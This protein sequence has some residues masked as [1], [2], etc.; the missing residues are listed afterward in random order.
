MVYTQGFF[1]D[2]VLKTEFPEIIRV[3]VANALESLKAVQFGRADAALVELAVANHL[4]RE[5]MLTGLAVKGDFKSS[6][7]DIEKLNIA[8]RNDWPKLQS[9]LKKA[10]QSITEDE[11]KE[12]QKKWIGYERKKAV[13]LSQEETAY[14]KTKGK[15]SYCVDPNRAPLEFID[16]E[17]ST[18]TEHQGI[19]ADMLKLLGDRLNIQFQ[20]VTTRDW[21]ESQAKVKDHV[22]D[23]LPAAIVNEE[24]KQY[25]NFTEPWLKDPLVVATTNKVTYAEKFEELIAQDRSFGVVSSYAIFKKL[26]KA[27]PDARFVAVKHIEEGLRKVVEGELFGFIDTLS[28][29]GYAI[30]VLHLFELRIAVKMDISRDAS[31]A[32][33][34]DELELA[35]ILQKGL[36]SITDDEMLTIRN[37]WIAVKFD[38]GINWKQIL[39]W[40]I[41]IFAGIVLIIATILV[42]NRK[43]GKEISERKRTEAELVKTTQAVKESEERFQTIAATTPGA[44]IQTRFDPEGRPEYLYLSAKAE[45]FF[46]MPPD[47]VIQR[48]KRLQWYHEDQKRIHEEIRTISSAGE[49][50]NL[51][52]RIEPAEGEIKWIRINASPSRSS[53]GGVIYNGFILDI[54]GRKLAEQE[55]LVSERKVKAMSQAVDDALVMING[56]GEVM[57]WNQAAEDLFGYT[58]KEAMG[59]DF[60]K[61]AVPEEERVKTMAGL[62]CFS[63]TGEG[64]VIGS[65]LKVT[66]KNRNGEEFPVE[67]SISAFQVDDEWFAVG[68]VRDI[69]ERKRAE[70]ELKQKMEEMERLNNLT[71]GREGKMIQLK[72]EINE[73]RGRLGMKN[74]YKIVS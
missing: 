70:E 16:K 57:F 49:D 51:V 42:W 56:K 19:T 14:L 38:A 73:L 5:N 65:G 8:V 13:E 69:T 45:Q 30:R 60:H 66:A 6:D 36:K 58:A 27:Y 59:M 17:K 50:M 48:K 18:K 40:V 26:Q 31:I 15:I 10:M 72:E 35:A 21:Q 7:P 52:G 47:Q 54:T 33:R 1:Y 74:R 43:L 25:L 29:V 24:R 55:Y 46:G 44:I 37:R 32:V 9:I 20:L 28:S 63:R 23:I 64:A 12:L 34:N 4:I 41:P 3:Q 11:A 53:E 61:M 22:C 67:V 2:E 39:V 71:I 62:E 68:T